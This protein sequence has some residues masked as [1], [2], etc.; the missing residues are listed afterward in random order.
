MS[1]K[2]KIKELGRLNTVPG[3][4]KIETWRVS[5][6]QI[7]ITLRRNIRNDSGSESK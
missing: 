6:L 4:L 5:R 1:I 7:C 3:R 2:V